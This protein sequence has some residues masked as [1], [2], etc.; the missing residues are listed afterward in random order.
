MIVLQMSYVLFLNG[1]FFSCP[2]GAL[3]KFY[4]EEI[5]IVIPAHLETDFQSLECLES[6]WRLYPL[7]GGG[8]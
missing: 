1:K 6:P 5:C 2:D 4:G 8:E 7:M 3:I